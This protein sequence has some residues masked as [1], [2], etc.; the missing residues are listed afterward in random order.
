MCVSANKCAWNYRFDSIDNHFNLVYPD[1]NSIYFI[2]VIPENTSKFVVS[3]KMTDVYNKGIIPN[4]PNADYF[5][6][7]VYETGNFITATF[8]INDKEL[9]GLENLTHRM[10]SYEYVLPLNPNS[11]YIGM[12]RIYTPHIPLSTF[13][14]NRYAVHYWSG[15]PPNTYI[16]NKLYPICNIDYTH[17][18]NIYT[19][20]SHDINPHTG[21]V[22]NKNDVF[23]FM[24]VPTGSLTNADA[25]YMIACVQTGLFY[26][27]SVRMP[28][29]MCS[30]GYKS[31]DQ[32]PWIN[33]TYDLRYASLNLVSTNSPRPTID[34]WKIPCD[35][36]NFTISI[37]VDPIIPNPAFLYRQ[38]MPDDKFTNSIKYAKTKCFDYVDNRYDDKCI[39]YVMDIYYPTVY[40]V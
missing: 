12:F 20:F 39:A 13:D 14:T 1:K 23:T 31:D 33:E 36:E 32:H 4:Y 40:V 22:C 3:N 30:S 5:S 34:S 21:T 10:G 9:M 8:H 38:I 6:I 7:Q 28:T 19:N 16:D 17:H 37:W 2:M 26:N 15:L 29:M 35:Q 18:D 27:I 11:L 25:N 24:N